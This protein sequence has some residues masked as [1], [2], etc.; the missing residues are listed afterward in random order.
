MAVRFSMSARRQALLAALGFSVGSAVPVA[1]LVELVWGTEPPRTAEKTL[2]S[3]VARLREGLGSETVV[4]VGNAYLLDLDT[5]AVDVGRFQA[6]FEAGD[7]SGA[8]SEWRGEPL[9]GLD[10]P[11]LGPIVTRLTEQWLNA[12]ETDLERTIESNPA[13]GVA[14]LTQL[15]DTHPFREGLWALLMTAL[16]AT[17]RQA[18]ALGAYGRARRHLVDE[19]GVE[20]RHRSWAKTE[21]FTTTRAMR[22][23][24]VSSLRAPSRSRSPRLRGPQ[25]CGRPTDTRPPKRSLGTKR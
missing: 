2:Q 4:R 14:R 22:R 9:A 15:T 6:R 25:S 7:I 18:D 21:S 12:V 10:A 24:Q 20:P 1:R 23:R 3:Y 17:G 5:E 11:G 13:A 19:L 8:L 16:Y